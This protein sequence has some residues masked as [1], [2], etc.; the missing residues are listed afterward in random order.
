M[1]ISW[2]YDYF[3]NDGSPEPVAK[4]QMQSTN[5]NNIYFYDVASPTASFYFDLYWRYT[6]LIKPPSNN[7]VRTGFKNIDIVFGDFSDYDNQIPKTKA[8]FIPLLDLWI[9]HAYNVMAYRC[10]VN[11]SMDSYIKD[12]PI[13]TDK[14][15]F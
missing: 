12:D 15:V 14:T 13:Y 9:L 5:V 2:I 1:C 8:L 11:T 3:L 4:L 6:I 10:N 7:A